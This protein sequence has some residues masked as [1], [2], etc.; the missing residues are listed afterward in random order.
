M[1]MLPYWNIIWLY[2][3]FGNKPNEP[4]TVGRVVHARRQASPYMIHMIKMLT[5]LLQPWIEF[6]YL[7]T[8]VSM[9]IFL[10][11]QG[12]QALSLARSNMSAGWSPICVFGVNTMQEAMRVWIFWVWGWVGGWGGV[13]C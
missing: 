11:L 5:D 12:S 1:H 3:C 4:T 8:I 7:H 9:N 13:G 2:S 10:L 6:G